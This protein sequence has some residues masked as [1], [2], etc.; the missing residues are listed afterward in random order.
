VKNKLPSLL[1]IAGAVLLC[2]GSTCGGGT[3]SQQ[4]YVNYADQACDTLDNGVPPLGCPGNSGTSGLTPSQYN[5][6]AGTDADPNFCGVCSTTD[7]CEYCPSGY[8]C[9]ADPCGS[10]C[11][12]AAT[13]PSGYPINCNDGFCCPENYSVCCS[14]GQTCGTDASACGGGNGGNNSGTCGAPPGGCSAEGAGYYAA[15][16]ENGCC[17]SDSSC[18]AAC[19]DDCGNAWYEANGRLFGPCSVES[20][21]YQTCIN[22]AASAVEAA[23]GQ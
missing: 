14:D 3:E 12:P 7:K 6:P 16:L 9:P 15:K 1:L 13:C 17:V 19:S 11:V 5:C 10:Q 2:S 22:N 20:A 18:V 23:C 8:G 4:S 21:D